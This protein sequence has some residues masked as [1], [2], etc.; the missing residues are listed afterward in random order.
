MPRPSLSV[1]VLRHPLKQV[2]Q[3]TAPSTYR[4][5]DR[6][7]G[8]VDLT[9]L[10]D[11]GA[12]RDMISSLAVHGDDVARDA[13]A[14]CALIGSLSFREQSAT[15]S[16]RPPGMA[17]E[18]LQT[19]RE[20]GVDVAS[21]AAGN[22]AFVIVDAARECVFLAVDRFAIETLCYRADA[23]TLAFSDRADCV[24]GRGKEL[25]PQAIFDYLYFHMIPAP[26]SYTH[27]DVYKRQVHAVGEAHQQAHQHRP[28]EMP[29]AQ[30]D[31]PP[32]LG[33]ATAGLAAVDMPTCLL[34]T[35]R[36]V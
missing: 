25:D 27:L 21:R 24:P 33:A 29:F 26:V 23:Q 5:Q 3:S 31:A 36:C 12:A 8:Q 1:W 17:A 14:M 10:F 32:G 11:S 19:W 35:S 4:M 18:L 2:P 16:L 13:D 22:Y 9:R 34:Y 20:K 15:G 28:D 30:S 7:S 6:L